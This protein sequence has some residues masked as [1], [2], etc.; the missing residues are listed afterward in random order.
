M[1]ESEIPANKH[2]AVKDDQKQQRRQDILEVAWKL[3]QETSYQAITMAEVAEKTGLAKGTV[4]LYFK[5]KEELFISIQEQQLSD[6]LDDIDTRLDEAHA[7]GQHEI[8]QVATLLCRSLQHRDSLTRLLAILHTILEQ[9]I[10][11]ASALR[12]KHM[13]LARLVA[14]GIKLEQVLPFLES[15]QGMQTLL[16]I[17]AF[18]IG[19]QHLADPAPIV[20]QVLEE[21]GLGAMKIDFNREFSE[22]IEIILAGL[23]SKKSKPDKES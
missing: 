15:G 4:Y 10:E 18:I 2:R 11:F 20:R 3:F 7:N 6:W 23:E 12:F 17:Y 1:A 16:R 14:T 9:N 21:P 13:V 8:K 5:T 19:L 22:T